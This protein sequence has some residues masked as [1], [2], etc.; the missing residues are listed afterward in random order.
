MSYQQL[1]KYTEDYLRTHKE[2]SDQEK[3]ALKDFLSEHAKKLDQLRAEKEL[4]QNK[5]ERSTK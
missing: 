5:R 2:I 1:K 3:Q 4:L